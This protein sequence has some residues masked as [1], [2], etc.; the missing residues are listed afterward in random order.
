MD[1][2]AG[3]FDMSIRPNDVQLDPSFRQYQLIGEVERRYSIAGKDGK[4]AG[5]RLC[6]PRQD[7]DVR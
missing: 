7:G 2:R 5:H 1:L 3:V 4:I 6:K